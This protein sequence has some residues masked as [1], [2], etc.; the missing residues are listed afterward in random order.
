[1]NDVRT[2]VSVGTRTTQCRATRSATA[3]WRTC[4]AD[5]RGGCSCLLH[6]LS[7]D[8][9]VQLARTL[10]AVPHLD[11]DEGRHVRRQQREL[12]RADAVGA[13]E[14][15][16]ATRCRCGVYTLTT[17]TRKTTRPM[18]NCSQQ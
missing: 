14:H 16:T 17:T 2:L 15:D 1:M 12:G 5:S 9:V 18:G 4:G 7:T 8:A 11:V 6:V 3:I 10:H 13:V